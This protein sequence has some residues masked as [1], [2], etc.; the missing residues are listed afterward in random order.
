MSPT[1]EKLAVTLGLQPHPEGGWFRETYRAEET[2]ETARGTRAAATAILFL[3]TSSSI[4]RLHR[5]ASDELWIHQSGLPLELVTL[6]PSGELETRVLGPDLPQALVRA[7]GWQA[8]RVTGGLD[9][10]PAQAWA[11]VSCV[12][13]PGFDFVDFE[14][15]DR[16]A[17]QAEFPR[18]AGIIGQLT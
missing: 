7:Y 1:A 8:A 17:L 11:L 14:L 9:L 4:S 16:Q 6:T 3:V 2:V 15:A 5:L 10:P 13:S 18:H 12:V